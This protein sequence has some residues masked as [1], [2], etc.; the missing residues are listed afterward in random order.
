MKSFLN[1]AICFQEQNVLSNIGFRDRLRIG[2]SGQKSGFENL[3][4][5]KRLVY[6]GLLW[7]GLTSKSKDS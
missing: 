3:Q 2:F 4:D 7:R 1:Q 5:P 6:S